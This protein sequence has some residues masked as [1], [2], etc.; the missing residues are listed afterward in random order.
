MR[1]VN[2]YLDVISN[3]NGAHDAYLDLSALQKL[4]LEVQFRSSEDHMHLLKQAS[5]LREVQFTGGPFYST[6]LTRFNED[7]YI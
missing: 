5:Y 7:L 4:S 1:S 3:R 6:N 2:E